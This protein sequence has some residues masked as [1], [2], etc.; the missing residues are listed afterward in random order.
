MEWKEKVVWVVGASTG[1]GR[2]LAL[3]LGSKGCTLILSSRDLRKLQEVQAQVNSQ[4]C[5]ILELDLEKVDTLAEKVSLAQR[6]V[7]R[8]DVVFLNGGIS[9]RSSASET[10]LDVDRRLMEINYFSYV[11]LTKCL[12]P[13]MIEQRGGHFVVT[14]SLSGKFGFKLRSSYSASKHALHGFFES[15]RLEE[16]ASG[17]KVTIICPGLI[18]T[19][20]S[21]NALTADG[22]K[23]NSMDEN[24]AQGVSA[25][26]CAQKMIV[27]VE[28]NKL[29]AVV[30]GKERYS[31][32][33]SR[34]FPLYLYKLLLKRDARG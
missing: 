27:A 21:L 3:N 2:A 19:D 28:K 17:I 31:V 16:V 10:L 9:Q 6:F 7:G 18:K 23:Q 5:H 15:L 32:L 20:I 25:E 1:I 13:S 8:I 4:N 26:F 12:L 24:Q 14:S 22:S 11:Q 30:G 33:L 34:L 29:E